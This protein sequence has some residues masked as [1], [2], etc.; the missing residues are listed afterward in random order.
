MIPGQAMGEVVVAQGM[1][2]GG[3]FLDAANGSQVV[4]AQGSTG[5][6]F[7]PIGG[8]VVVPEYFKGVGV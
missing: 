5:N 1:P 8:I 7:Q 4:V 3:L 2:S 6:G